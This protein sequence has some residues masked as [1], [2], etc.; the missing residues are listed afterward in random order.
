MSGLVILG[1]GFDL[2]HGLHTDYTY[3][4]REILKNDNPDLFKTVDEMFF[5]NNEKLWRDFESRVGAFTPSFLEKFIDKRQELIGEY[6]EENSNPF[7]YAFGPEDENYGDD[8]TAVDNAIYQVTSCKPSADNL[9]DEDKELSDIRDFLECGLRKMVLQANIDLV[10]RKR[11]LNFNNISK[12]V[13]F[14]FTDTVED[15]YRIDSSDV[16]HIHG[17]DCPIWGNVASR[18][19]KSEDIIIDTENLYYDPPVVTEVDEFGD[20]QIYSYP[21]NVVDFKL[22]LSMDE[23]VDDFIKNVG[24]TLN[25]FEKALSEPELEEFLRD[26]SSSEIDR[27]FVIGH[28]LGEVDIPYFQLIADKFP[29]A[30]WKIS[31]YVEDEASEFL[32]KAGC[33]LSSEGL[34]KLQICKIGS[35]FL[36]I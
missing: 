19:T 3:T 17:T 22:A 12:V 36:D 5:E 9:V 1:N 25:E 34:S 7:M 26:V 23:S 21:S 11:L 27:I 31:Y 6:Y 16:L 8:Y 10:D 13:T 14:N 28:S 4:Y 24:E 30:I 33:F 32:S 20:T 18:L 15:L 35:D 29:D 2:Y